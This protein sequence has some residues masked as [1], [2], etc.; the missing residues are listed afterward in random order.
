MTRLWADDE[1]VIVTLD[2][3]GLPAAFGWHGRTHTVERIIDLWRIDTDW[4]SDAGVV[5]RQYVQLITRGGLLCEIYHDLSPGEEA[6][7]WMM[8]RVYD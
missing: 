1:P 2:A 4:W 3:A 5:S 6:G 8:A 7:V